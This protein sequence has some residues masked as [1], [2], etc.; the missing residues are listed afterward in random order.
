M[1]FSRIFPFTR[2]MLLPL[3]FV[4]YPLLFHLLDYLF[5]CDK[6]RMPLFCSGIMLLSY[7]VGVCLVC[8]FVSLRP[9]V[10]YFC[11]LSLAFDGG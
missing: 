1:K 7:G 11:H 6:K 3:H 2:Q 8:F 4:F 5:E 9:T 10:Y